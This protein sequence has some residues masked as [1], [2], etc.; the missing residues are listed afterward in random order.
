MSQEPGPIPEDVRKFVMEY[1][2]SFEMLRVLVLLYETPD[3]TWTTQEITMELRSAEGAIE[4]RLGDLYVRRIL[5]RP[6]DGDV[7]RYVACSAEMGE[8]IT[9]LVECYHVRPYR[10]IDMIYSRPAEAL[11][12]FADAFRIRKND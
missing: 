3:R 8:V 5:Q 4:K 1:V 10:I 6:P 11:R 2:D 7:H 9:Q 12:A